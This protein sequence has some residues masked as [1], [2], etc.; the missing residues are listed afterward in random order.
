MAFFVDTNLTFCQ[1]YDKISVVKGDIMNKN[2]YPSDI[3][4]WKK[5]YE[6]FEE[7]F[8][9]PQESAFMLLEK[10]A[11]K[12]PNNIAI[13]YMNFKLTFKKYIDKIINEASS[14]KKLGVKK[15]EIVPVFLPNIPEARTTIYALNIV[16]AIAYP[17]N[18][19]LPPKEFEKLLIEN[20]VKNLFMFNMFYQKYM[21]AIQNSSVENVIMTYGTDMIPKYI[22]KFKNILDNLK[23]EKRN[24]LIPDSV[25]SWDEFIISKS[26]ENIKPIY[27]KNQT[28]VIIGTSGTT[29]TPKG[30]CLTNENLNS[31]ALE[32]LNGS[33]NF[34]PGDKMLDIL[35]PSIGYGLSV[36]HYEGV[37]GLETI[38]I[39]TLQS[40]IY[41][42]LKKYK[43]DHFAGGPIHYENLVSYHENDPIIYGK[44]FVSGGASLPK[45]IE[46]KLNKIKEDDTFEEKNIFVRQGLGCTENGGASTYAKKGAYKPYG[47]GIPLLY[48]TV[49]IFKPGTDVELG[50]NTDGEICIN[51]PTVMK[52]YL[53]NEEETN[54]VLKKHKD[55]KIWLHTADI[56]YM[57]EDGQIFIKDRIK[58]IFARRGFNVHPNTVADFISSLPIVEKAFVMGINHPDE[59]MVPVAFIK[60][61]EEMP[62]KEAENIINENCY[63]F[64]EETSIPYEIVFVSDLPLNLGGKVDTKKLLELSQID[65][66]KNKE[67]SFSRV[68]NI[69]KY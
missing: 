4:P 6:N 66:F 42:L 14:L 61:K 21:L 63:Q 7:N 43:P 2:M 18:P 55:G 11:N 32:H 62:L 49:G 8:V 64:L 35:I 12:M 25:I 38:L 48:E 68:L 23:K 24:T 31:M 26:K 30:V 9:V 58:N 22:L 65:Y 17:I 13:N 27:E 54:E 50:F 36:M 57:D 45:T 52:E 46:K 3:K 16:G 19:L 69:P 47:V 56:G 15:G 5:Y 44:N 59:Q 37:C 60:L 53:N 20:N 1:F 10:S 40:D 67:K 28:S 51:G 41:P 29:G 33:L 34:K 39:P